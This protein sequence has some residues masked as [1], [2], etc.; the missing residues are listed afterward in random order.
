MA[1]FVYPVGSGGGSASADIADFI[2]INEDED[3]STMTLPINKEMTIETTRDDDGDADINIY[4][5]D[6]IFITARGDDVNISAFNEVSIESDD[7]NYTWTFTNSGNLDL[8]GDGYISNPSSS[9]GDPNTPY[10]DTLHLVPDSDLD[11]DRYIILDPTSPNHIHIRAG[12][13]MDNSLAQLILGGEKANVS[14]TDNSHDVGISTYDA[15]GD[16]YYGWNFGNDGVLAGPAMGGLIVNSLFGANEQNLPIYSGASGAIVLGGENGE[17]LNDPD[18]PANQI[19]TIGDVDTATDKAYISLYS[20]ADQGPYTEN[21]IQPFTYTNVDFSNDISLVE[22]SLITF[23][24]A[25]KY[26]LSFSAQLHQT[27]SSGTIEIWLRKNGNNV[28]ATNT[29]MAI[30]SNNP[31]YVA[32]WNFFIDAA[33]GDDFELVWSSTSANTVVE[34]EAA[35]GS[36]PTEHPEIPSII[37]TVN[38]ID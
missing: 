16:N 3:N 5:A 32:A 30:T 25:G 19:A 28:P 4:S 9:S 18:I 13:E 29:R 31:Y 1:R 24:K 15:E 23:A 35:S 33:V 14:V 37:L 34:Y 26:N 36:G 7:E 17:F 12:G 11:N 10:V 21:A 20:T 38:Q 6:D 22:G 2:F 8:P 27:N